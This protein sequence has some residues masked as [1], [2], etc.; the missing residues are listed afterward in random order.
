MI[1]DPFI[2]E[3]VRVMK[4]AGIDGTVLGF[5]QDDE[6]GIEWVVMRR[7]AWDDEA[8]AWLPS[9]KL[10]PLVCERESLLR[11]KGFAA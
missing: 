2:G 7:H 10:V 11:L 8:G 1:A 4:E 3:V 5:F 9:K 6:A